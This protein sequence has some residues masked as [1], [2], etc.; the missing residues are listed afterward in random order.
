MLTCSFGA[1]VTEGHGTKWMKDF[2]HERIKERTRVVG[3][4]RAGRGRN[5]SE[6]RAY[7][8]ADWRFCHYRKIAL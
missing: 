2:Y 8:R 7:C 4:V 6:D 1:D 5:R 3:S